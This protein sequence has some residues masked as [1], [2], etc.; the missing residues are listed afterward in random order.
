MFGWWMKVQKTL[1]A[2]SLRPIHFVPV[3]YVV[4]RVCWFALL[5]SHVSA[6]VIDRDIENRL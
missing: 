2:G 6:E 4:D 5:Q 3:L 1:C